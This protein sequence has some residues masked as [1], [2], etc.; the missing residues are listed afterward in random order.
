MLLIVYVSPFLHSLRF[1]NRSFGVRPGCELQRHLSL[2]VLAWSSLLT[3]QTF[4]FWSVKWEGREW[5]PHTPPLVVNKITINNTWAHL[6]QSLPSCCYR[7]CWRPV[8][9]STIKSSVMGLNPSPSFTRSLGKF[10][11]LSHLQNLNC[12]K[13]K[14]VEKVYQYP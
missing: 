4:S 13:K 5:P 10:L 12:K 14:K 2:S 1:K 3:S 6:V 9:K 8:K 11:S 7:Q